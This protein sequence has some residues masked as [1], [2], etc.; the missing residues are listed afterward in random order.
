M[1][2]SPVAPTATSAMTVRFNKAD[3]GAPQAIDS[4][5]PGDLHRPIT[6]LRADSDPLDRGGI[7]SLR[8][9]SAR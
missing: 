2:S 1:G 4:A 3:G 6:P 7:C 8:I 5:N 9:N